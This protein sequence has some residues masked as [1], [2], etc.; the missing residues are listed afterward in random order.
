MGSSEK[1][2]AGRII[3]NFTKGETFSSLMTTKCSCGESHN[4]A[5]LLPPFQKGLPL[6]VGLAKKKKYLA[7]QL[8]AELT[9]FF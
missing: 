2:R 4:V 6:T 5:A 1:Q 9:D 7:A 3:S 8:K